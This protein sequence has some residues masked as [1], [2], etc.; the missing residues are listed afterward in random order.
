MSE[1]RI[2][3]EDMKTPFLHVLHMCGQLS[4]DGVKWCTEVIV[5]RCICKQ[6]LSFVKKQGV[7]LCVFL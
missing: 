7:K 6:M 4:V 1:W 2:G 5:C 3:C